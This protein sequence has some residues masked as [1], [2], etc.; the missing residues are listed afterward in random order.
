[1]CQAGQEEFLGSPWATGHAHA[2]YKEELA[3]HFLDKDPPRERMETCP[4]LNKYSLGA[5][6][7]TSI[8]QECS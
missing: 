4:S 1:M 6:Y 2:P 8:I 5:Y 3:L 7:V